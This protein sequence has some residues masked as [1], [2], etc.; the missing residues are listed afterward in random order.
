MKNKK[1]KKRHNHH[2]KKKKK[3]PSFMA[4]ISIYTVDGNRN[5][6]FT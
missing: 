6:E 2:L 3:N 5:N 4:L 1:N